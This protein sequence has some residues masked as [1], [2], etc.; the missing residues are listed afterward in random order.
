MDHFHTTHDRSVTDADTMTSIF[1]S[2]ND[3]GMEVSAAG[4]ASF[5]EAVGRGELPI[6]NPGHL[7]SG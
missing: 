4:P 3:L 2:S 5:S 7:F 1:A 6:K